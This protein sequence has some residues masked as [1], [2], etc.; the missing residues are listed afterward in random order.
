MKKNEKRLMICNCEGTMPLDGAALG[1]A[2]GSDAPTLYSQLCRAQLGEFQRAVLEDGPLIVACTQEAPLFDEVRGD[3]ASNAD[4]GFTNIRER[5]GW[6]AEA[7]DATPKIA[8]LLAEAAMDIPPTSSVTLESKGVVLVYGRDQTALDAARQLATRADVTVLLSRPE[9]VTPPRVFDLPVFHGTISRA[10]GHLGAFELAV[11]DYAAAVPSAKTAMVFGAAQD[12]AASAC[13]VIIDLTGETPLFPAPEKRDGYFNPD[14][15]NPAQVQKAL[16]DAS[17]LIGEFEKPRYIAYQADICAHSRNAKVGCNRCIDV[18]PTSAITPDGD[19]VAIDP[20]VCA[21][22]GACASVCPTGAA[23]YDLPP[24]NTVFQRLRT[25]FGA[26]RDAGG[27]APALLVHDPR[28][29]DDMISAMARH[30]RGLPARVLPFAVNEVTQIG[31][32]FFAVAFAYGAVQVRV[33]AGPANRQ[34]RDALASQIALAE[35]VMTGLGYDSGRLGIIDADDPAAVE[36]A[37]YNLTVMAAPEAGRFLAMGSKRTVIGLALGHLHAHAPAPVDIL[38]LASGAP[39]GAI[40]VAVDGCTLCLACVGACPTGALVDNPDHPMLRF[41]EEA[42]VQCGLCRNTCPESVM[43][44]VPRI[45][46]TDGVR[47][48]VVV[49]QEEPFAC[50]RCG[51]PFGVA[52]TIER[53]VDQLSDHAMFADDPAALER[54]RMCDDC[55][56]IE[57]FEVPAPMASRPKP[58]TRT[59]E[60]DLRE[61]EKADARAAHERAQKAE[62]DE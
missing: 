36:A 10:T 34:E 9:A 21:G 54:I 55:R 8:A 1:K 37:L 11:D 51:K 41:N 53:M 28:H 38:P 45:N 42:C 16:F 58:I 2:C 47:V 49:K 61:R 24:G 29:G 43:S 57:Q 22:C 5:A 20:F 27:A 59:T 12:G 39:F 25:L 14:P 19:H 30:G 13:D 46:F 4:L 18:C 33:L 17:D 35:T 31:F 44:L 3:S 23:A 15:A 32:D 26:Y 48:P 6:S 7:A 62:D 50:V 60:D 40:E 56:V 52:S